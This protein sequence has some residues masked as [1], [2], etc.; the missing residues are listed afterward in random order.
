M[1]M[2]LNIYI[3]VHIYLTTPHELALIRT[4]ASTVALYCSAVEEEDDTVAETVAV[5]AIVKNTA[6][7]RVFIF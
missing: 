3:Y 5:A 4:R 7:I 6:T 1:I 2:E